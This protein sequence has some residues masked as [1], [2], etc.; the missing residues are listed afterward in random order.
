[1]DRGRRE[2]FPQVGRAYGGRCHNLQELRKAVGFGVGSPNERGIGKLTIGL[3]S[4]Q[5]HR[6]PQIPMLPAFKVSAQIVVSSSGRLLCLVYRQLDQRP[7][8]INADHLRANDDGAK[9][10]FADAAS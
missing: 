1:M 8:Q 4:S 7:R 9:G 6:V 10:T 3:K 2:V 5:S